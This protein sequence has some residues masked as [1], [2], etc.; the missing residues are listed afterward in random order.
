MRRRVDGE[1]YFVEGTTYVSIRSALR[2]LSAEDISRL[3]F[4][5]LERLVAGERLEEVREQLR[6]VVRVVLAEADRVESM[7]DAFRLLTDEVSALSKSWRVAGWLLPPAQALPEGKLATRVKDCLR[8][9][10]AVL[11]GPRADPNARRRVLFLPAF[12]LT[13]DALEGVDLLVSTPDGSLT[14]APADPSLLPFWNARATRPTSDRA[15]QRPASPAE[16]ID[17]ILEQRE[18]PENAAEL[19]LLRIWFAGPRPT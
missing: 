15:P 13:A 19:E 12:N 1:P 8:V 10:L 2:A 5:G 14:P 16:L 17:R 7:F 11:C 9:R 6:D 3:T 18:H 4:D